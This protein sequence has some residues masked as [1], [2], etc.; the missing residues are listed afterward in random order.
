M[1]LTNSG[2]HCRTGSSSHSTKLESVTSLGLWGREDKQRVGG[3]SCGW[4]GRDGVQKKKIHGEVMEAL[5]L[6]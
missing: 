4:R 5:D 1:W 6:Y 3:Q 2:R